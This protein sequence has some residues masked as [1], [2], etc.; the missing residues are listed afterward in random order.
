MNSE[1]KEPMSEATL[2]S[3]LG[4]IEQEYRKGDATEH[5]YR[6]AFKDLLD[7]LG[8]S[9]QISATNEP[10]RGKHGAPDYRVVRE[11]GQNRFTIGYVEAKDIGKALDEEEKS[12]QMKRYRA[13]LQNLILTDYLEFR[14]YLNGEHRQT[15]RLARLGAHG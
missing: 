12:E 3:Y 1:G 10:K 6:P 14:W 2:R 7:A 4:K 11:Q 9:Q 8:H 15:V 5:S 13:N